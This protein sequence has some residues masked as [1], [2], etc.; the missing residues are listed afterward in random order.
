MAIEVSSYE[1][2]LA[3]RY[4]PNHVFQAYLELPLGAHIMAYLRGIHADDIENQVPNDQ[5][6]QDNL[7][8]L[9]LNNQLDG[10]T[11]HFLRLPSLPFGFLDA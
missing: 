9:Q 8:L 3:N 4:T 7:V 2:L 6:D 5:L 10:G 1:G 11:L